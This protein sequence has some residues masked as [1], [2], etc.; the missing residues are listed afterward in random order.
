M[1]SCPLLARHHTAEAEVVSSG[2]DFAHA[3]RANHVMRAVLICAEEGSSAVNS[4]ELARFIRIERR[5]RSLRIACNPTQRR[6]LLI[7]VR[8]VPI[9]RPLPHIAS[10]VIQILLLKTQ[11]RRPGIRDLSFGFQHSEG[12]DPSLAWT[13]RPGVR[14]KHRAADKKQS[15]RNARFLAAPASATCFL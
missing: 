1:S 10:H 3:S 8:T 5:I 7:V 11:D 15:S 2:A 6:Q 9:P 12:C 4:L 13:N 14:T